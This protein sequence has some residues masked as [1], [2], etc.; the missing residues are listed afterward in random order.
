MA[1]WDRRKASKVPL[2]QTPCPFP[3]GITVDL[4]GRA[5]EQ[6]LNPVPPG[7]GQKANVGI[8]HCAGISDVP[9]A[10][11]LSHVVGKQP[12]YH[13]TAAASISTRLPTVPSY[14]APHGSHLSST[15]KFPRTPSSSPGWC[16]HSPAPAQRIP[17]GRLNVRVPPGCGIHE[18]PSLAVCPASSTRDMNHQPRQLRLL[19]CIFYRIPCTRHGGLAVFVC[20]TLHFLPH[21]DVLY[22]QLVAHLTWQADVGLQVPELASGQKSLVRPSTSV[23][24]EFYCL[25]TAGSMSEENRVTLF[26]SSISSL[27]LLPQPRA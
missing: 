17:K 6:L 5:M 11:C 9:L 8:L 2:A 3:A 14:P 23:G 4:K 16:P 7:H 19:K 10:P 22:L 26:R 24:G 27:F 20:S 21:P 13:T 15:E 18:Y 1:L 25:G 12:P